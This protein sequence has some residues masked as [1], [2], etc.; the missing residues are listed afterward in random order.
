[1]TAMVINTRY[2]KG[3]L[4]S[5][6]F[7]FCSL[8]TFSQPVLPQRLITAYATQ[9][10]HF[11]TFCLT[12]AAGGTVT[13]TWDNVRTCDGN[14]TLLSRTP[15]HQPAIFAIKLCEGRNVILTFDTTT[16]LEG[17]NGGENLTLNLGPSEKGIS[18]SSFTTNSDCNFTTPLRMG[19]TLEVPGSAVPGTYTG[20][21]AITFIQQ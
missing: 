19:G 4:F 1:M 11:G 12:G 3:L 16:F 15:T 7:C 6:L 17:S 9:G 21:F 10:I 18:G 13:V 5:I 2:I 20:S 8:T 14:I